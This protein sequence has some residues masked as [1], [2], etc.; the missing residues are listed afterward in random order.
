MTEADVRERGAFAIFD[1]AGEIR[2]IPAEVDHFS[3]FDLPRKLGIDEAAL[4]RAYY[5]LS[6]KLHPDFFQNAPAAK[7]VRSLDASARLNEAYKAL[8]DPVRR[9]V[10]LVELESGKMEE[11]SAIPPAEMLEEIFEAQEAVEE[12]KC[13]S[14]EEEAE[15]LRGRLGAAQECFVALRSGQRDALDDL[16]K[17][18]DGS[19]E[20]G[21]P[22]SE[23]LDKMRSILSQR[24]YIN[25]VLR[26]IEGALEDAS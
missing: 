12:F 17:K 10:Y 24:N 21:A 26:S 3:L 4:E 11:N 16:A 7:R 22:S 2:T 13:C 1:D 20:A 19:L 6:R 15:N 25:N 14:E 9:A 23:A 8:K 5:A 18:W